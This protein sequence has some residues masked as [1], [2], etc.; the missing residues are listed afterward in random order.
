VPQRTCVGCRQVLPK[1]ALVRIVRGPSGVR[2]DPTG[3]A[4][5]R[6]AYIHD[7]R[8]CWETALRGPLAQALKTELTPEARLELERVLDGLP[9]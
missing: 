5:G 3:K 2:L 9:A 6:G 1:R 8:S 4:A 7:Q